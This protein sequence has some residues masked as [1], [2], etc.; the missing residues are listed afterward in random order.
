MP[1]FI[2]DQSGDATIDSLPPP[3]PSGSVSNSG[4]SVAPS[5]ASR[6]H[7][8]LLRD[9]WLDSI[10]EQFDDLSSGLQDRILKLINQHHPGTLTGENHWY[11][12][13]YN[14]SI[15]YDFYD[16]SAGLSVS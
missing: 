14:L 13:S 2:S 6:L 15:A 12:G 11:Y 4:G 7:R 5:N 3:P 16:E 1:E 10:R 9:T 8:D